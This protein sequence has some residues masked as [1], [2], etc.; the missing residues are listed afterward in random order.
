L[1]SSISVSI[2]RVPASR[3]RVNRVIRPSKIRPG[4]SSNVIWAGSP[5][6]MNDASDW[7]T[8][9]YTRSRS[10]RATTSTGVEAAAVLVVAAGTSVPGS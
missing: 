10:I 7:G 9:T 2:V 3:A 6:R 4:N 8:Y 1:G 5:I